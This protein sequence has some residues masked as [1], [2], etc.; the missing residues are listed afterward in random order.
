MRL[1]ELCDTGQEWIGTADERPS[2]T[3]RETAT[4]DGAAKGGKRRLP[5][6]VWSE[7]L[8]NKTKRGKNEMYINNLITGTMTLGSGGSTPA[9]RAETRIW[10]SNN[11]DDYDD[12]LLEGIITWETFKSIGLLDGGDDSEPWWIKYPY[13]VEIGIGT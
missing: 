8:T 1:Y 10:W 5:E 11:E 2:R 3:G 4:D 9:T 12:Y 6:K 7:D 13:K